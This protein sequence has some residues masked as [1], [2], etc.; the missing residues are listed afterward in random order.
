MPRYVKRYAAAILL[1]GTFT[2]HASANDFTGAG[3]SFVYP[4]MSKWSSDYAKATGKKV[5]YQSIG[6]GGGIAQ[7][8]AVKVDF[9][10]TD[11]PQKPEELTKFGRAQFLSVIGGVV[12]VLKV[13]GVAPGARKLDGDLLA[14]IGSRSYGA[15]ES[16]AAVIDM[17]QKHH[18]MVQSHNRHAKIPQ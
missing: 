11:A 1:A 17:S 5:N 9:G 7:I 8:K 10:S 2:L 15:W 13:P 4:V 12:P 16:G 18:F 6:C 3:A 14:D